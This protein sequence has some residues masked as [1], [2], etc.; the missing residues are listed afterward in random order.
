MYRVVF[1]L[2]CII[3]IDGIP[4]LLQSLWR[5]VLYNSLREMRSS[6]Q[7]RHSN[8]LKDTIEAYRTLNSVISYA[9]KNNIQ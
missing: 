3:G 2:G 9:E 4:A 5:W 1:V 6:A 7:C 8:I